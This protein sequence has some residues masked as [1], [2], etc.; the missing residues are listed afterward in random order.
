MAKRR[1]KEKSTKTKVTIEVAV[2]MSSGRL[3]RFVVKKRPGPF[4]VNVT[5]K[6]IAIA[7]RVGL[8]GSQLIERALAKRLGAPQPLRLVRTRPKPRA[9]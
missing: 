9:R 7:R 5:T 4:T 1:T 6:D 3:A 8:T 2:K